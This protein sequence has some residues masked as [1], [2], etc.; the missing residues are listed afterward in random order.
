MWPFVENLYLAEQGLHLATPPPL[1]NNSGNDFTISHY[2]LH[3][4]A[5]LKCL[6]SLRYVSRQNFKKLLSLKKTQIQD[7]CKLDLLAPSYF[8]M[9]PLRNVNSKFRIPE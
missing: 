9:R 3:T 6:L 2:A 8:T 5:P 1:K 7:A 4:N